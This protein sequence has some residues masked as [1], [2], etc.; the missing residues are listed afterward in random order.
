MAKNKFI[1]LWFIIGI[2]TGFAAVIFFISTY[3]SN[4]V[5]CDVSCRVRNEVLISLILSSL[6]GVF[7]GSLTYYFISEKYEK[8]IIRIHKDI[9][10]TYKFLGEDQRLV[11]KSIVGDKG[12]ISQTK[13]V[14]DT[15]LSRV[16][17]SRCLKQLE[18]KEIIEKSKIGMTN[19]IML[20]K[21]LQDLFL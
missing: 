20:S 5:L 16:R 17:V 15:N 21:D 6:F 2:I 3:L 10:A 12:K 1:Q 13:L 9:S 7:I 14:K 8:K 4:K 18:E 19:K 11:L